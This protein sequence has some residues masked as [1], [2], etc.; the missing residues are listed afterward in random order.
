MK[1]RSYSTLDVETL[2]KYT[3]KKEDTMKIKRKRLQIL[4]VN[5]CGTRKIKYLCICQWYN[6]FDHYEKAPDIT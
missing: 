1:I 5:V 3:K 6:N 4:Y 2:C